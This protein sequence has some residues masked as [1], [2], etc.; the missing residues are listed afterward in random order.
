MSQRC[1]T[2]LWKPCSGTVLK[3]LVKR[4]RSCTSSKSTDLGEQQDAIN[5]HLDMGVYRQA[6]EIE[7][8]ERAALVA[9]L[10]EKP[11]SDNDC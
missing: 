3:P 11:A 5:A 1:R 2:G 6:V 8:A 9:W 4:L 10:K 7:A